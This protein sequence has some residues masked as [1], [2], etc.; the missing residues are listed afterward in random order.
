[1]KVLITAAAMIAASITGTRAE[2]VS[3]EFYKD[4]CDKFLKSEPSDQQMYLWWA[5][6][7]IG[8]ELEKDPQTAGIKVDDAKASQWLRDYCTAHPATAF[9]EA[10]DAAKTQIA[11]PSKP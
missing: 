9:A 7:R 4:S 10:T 1:M 2:V 5:T 11:G 6:G 8:K 3:L